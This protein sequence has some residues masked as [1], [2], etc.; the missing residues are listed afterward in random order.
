MCVLASA[1]S[2][3]PQTLHRHAESAAQLLTAY[4]ACTFEAG[5]QKDATPKHTSLSIVFMFPSE[6]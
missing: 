5:V 2:P 6:A 1:V 4:F 3:G